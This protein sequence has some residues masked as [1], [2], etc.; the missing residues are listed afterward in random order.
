MASVP[1]LKIWLSHSVSILAFTAGCVMLSGAVGTAQD[2]LDLRGPV[3]EP[4]TFGSDLTTAPNGQ[5]TAVDFE[6]LP[7]TNAETATRPTPQ[8]RTA[9]AETEDELTV[10][11]IRAGALDALDEDRNA[12]A[13]RDNI[14]TGSVEGL[15]RAPDDNPYAPLGLRAGSFVFTPTLEQGIGWT[16][17]A[18]SSPNGRSAI[19]SETGLRLNGVSDWSRHSLS[20]QVDGTYRESLSG[21]DI[22]EIEGGGRGDLRL[23]LGSGFA[24]Q[25]GTGY[26]VRPESASSPDPLEGVSSRPLRHTFT[27]TAGVSRSVGLL[28]LGVT[29]D[30]SRS[31]YGDAD[32]IGGGTLSQKDRNSTLATVALRAGYELSPALQP[33]VEGEI[34]RRL[35]D[36]KVDAEGYERSADRYGLRAGLQLDMGEKLRG[37]FSAGWLTERPDD[38]RLASLSA[39]T[40]AASLAWSPMRG[41][42]VELNG[43]TTVESTT[44]A[45]QTGSLL[46]SGSLAVSRELRANLTGRA[47]VGLDWRDYSGS[48][49]DEMILRGEASL[50]WWMNR[51]AGVTARARHE[52]QRSSIADR[53]Y[54]ATSVYLGMTFQR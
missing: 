17:N 20:V 33:F 4:A 51:Y 42:T 23:D 2:R 11:T 25:L 54:D 37:E 44:R 34:G 32:L 19:F 49:E 53:D 18:S 47:L 26:R 36:N 31:V 48:S 22:S 1:S 9:T 16:S 7:G 43:S 35:Y 41:T 13:P 38:D 45:G 39:P 24:A 46:Y 29:G 6:P 14:R 21:E 27:G 10:G 15:A 50:T 40:V 3:S 5:Q 28:S 8:R 30:V 52:L 12:R